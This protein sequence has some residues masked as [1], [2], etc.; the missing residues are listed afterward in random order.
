[1]TYLALLIIGRYEQ[2]TEESLCSRRSLWI[3]EGE[4]K[5]DKTNVTLPNYWASEPVSIRGNMPCHVMKIWKELK[6]VDSSA[7]GDRSWKY[8]FFSKWRFCSS[9]SK[10]KRMQG[11][12]VNFPGVKFWQRWFF[13]VLKT[14]CGRWLFEDRTTKD[15]KTTAV[16]P[17][18]FF[19]VK[20]LSPKIMWWDKTS[21]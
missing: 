3:Q 2:T 14:N 21:G 19:S 8:W 20:I 5:K 15:Y 1:M 17:K 12:S 6:N 7:S 16:A 9:Q 11:K 13:C 18:L 4:F 10:P